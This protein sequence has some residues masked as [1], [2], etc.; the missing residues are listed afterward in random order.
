MPI[1][2]ALGE[3]TWNQQRFNRSQRFLLT[4]PWV[5]GKYLFKLLYRS[6]TMM[7]IINLSLLLISFIYSLI[8]LEWA[9]TPQQ[10]PLNLCCIKIK[11]VYYVS[12]RQCETNRNVNETTEEVVEKQPNCLI[13]FFDKNHLIDSVRT[14]TRKRPNHGRLFLIMLI[15]GLG[16]YTFQRGILPFLGSMGWW[17]WN[18]MCV[19]WISD[20]RPMSYLY[21]NHKFNWTVDEFSDYR[22]FQSAIFVVGMFGDNT[23]MTSFKFIL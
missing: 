4:I 6:F 23:H 18:K 9:T 22:T 1:G 5:S 10:K 12:G 8:R 13:D 7:Y 11:N 2:V 20:E 19:N 3:S 21:T 17:R 14:V 15:L 16:L